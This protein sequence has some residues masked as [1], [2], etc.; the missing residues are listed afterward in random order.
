M[1]SKLYTAWRKNLHVLKYIA[2]T[3]QFSFFLIIINIKNTS[4]TLPSVSEVSNWLSL[5]NFFHQI[6]NFVLKICLIIAG[7]LTVS[8][9]KVSEI[10]ACIPRSRQKSRTSLTHQ[11]LTNTQPML[12]DHHQVH[13]SFLTLFF[14]E[15]AKDFDLALRHCSIFQRGMYMMVGMVWTGPLACL[16]LFAIKSVDKSH[17]FRL[18][19]SKLP[20]FPSMIPN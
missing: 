14:W 9:G 5:K 6:I 16:S 10:E 7:G 13:F 15:M 2:N 12:T 19:V 3:T 4:N 1:I 17:L 8:T 20:C 18:Q 11:T